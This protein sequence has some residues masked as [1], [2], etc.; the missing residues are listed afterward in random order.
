MG[1][2]NKA[3]SVYGLLKSNANSIQS[4]KFG[5]DETSPIINQ[6]YGAQKDSIDRR[7]NFDI[8]AA[9]QGAAA[10]NPMLTGSLKEDTINN[11]GNNIVQGK[12]D[13]YG[14]LGSGLMESELG[15]ME[16]DNKNTVMNQ[17]LKSQ[18]LAQ[19]ANF[20]PTLMQANNQPT[21]LDDVFALLNTGGSL[22][23]AVSGAKN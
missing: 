22:Y 17:Q 11:A 3:N 8:G 7:A 10:R 19:L 23:G 20:L 1:I 4:P 12:Y 21:W 2:Q 9:K 16:M 18:A 15:A 14:K 5:Y 13:A 6:L